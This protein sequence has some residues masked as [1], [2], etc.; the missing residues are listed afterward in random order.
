MVMRSM[1]AGFQDMR[2]VTKD[3]RI[4][5]IN[6]PIGL[7]R[8]NGFASHRDPLRNLVLQPTLSLKTISR[9]DFDRGSHRLQCL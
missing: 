2:Q 3:A 6:G 8:A 1:V 5:E 9:P 7:V 4:I